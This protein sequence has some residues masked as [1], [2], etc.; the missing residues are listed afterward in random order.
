MG[1]RQ[2]QHCR[3]G[4]FDPGRLGLFHY[5]NDGA[6]GKSLYSFNSYGATTVSRETRAVKVSFDRPYSGNGSGQFFWWEADY[7]RW[8]ER[9]GYRTPSELHERL[10]HQALM[11]HARPV[12][13]IL[14]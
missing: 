2:G 14:W 11:H 12:H 6:T 7:V 9:N 10:I 13:Q 4:P 1:P 3:L 8:L 5:P